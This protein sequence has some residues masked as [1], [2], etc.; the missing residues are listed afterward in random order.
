MPSPHRG[1]EVTLLIVTPKL[2]STSC[3]LAPQMPQEY[4]LVHL[5]HISMKI[6]KVLDEIPPSEI[7]SLET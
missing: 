5:F 4:S 3:I 6:L 7:P 1:V 2:V